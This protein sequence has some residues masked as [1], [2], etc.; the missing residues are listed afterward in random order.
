MGLYGGI[1]AG[2]TKVIC[3]VGETPLSIQVASTIRTTTP[4]E[5]LA[6]AVAFFRPYA[7]RGLGLATFG[8]VDLDR[9]SPTYGHI[10]ASPKLAW[11]GFPIVDALQKA[12]GVPVAVD[13]D[14]NAAALAEYAYGAGRGY[15]PLVYLTVGTG[16]GGGAVVRGQPLHG[17]LHPEM[18]HMLLARAPGDTLPSGC[19]FHQDCLEG[20]ASGSAMRLRFGAPEALP[21]RHEAWELEAKYLGQALATVSAVLSPQRLVIGGGVMRQSHLLPRL[22]DACAHALRG[23]LPRLQSANDFERYIVPPGLGERAGVVGA[24][25]LTQVV[26]QEA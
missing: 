19:P 12:L 3:A 8:P 2:G 16:I 15:D 5:T 11:Q 10:L 9:V 26:R 14:V 20:L 13:T 21:P 1:E 23:Y 7:L 6:Q 22:R 25:L 4:A 17:L 18:G 24:L